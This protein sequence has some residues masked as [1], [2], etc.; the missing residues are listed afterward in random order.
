MRAKLATLSL[1][2]QTVIAFGGEVE[3][4]GKANAAIATVAPV[5]I[6]LLLLLQ[7]FK[8]FRRVGLVLLTIPFA[9]AGI[10]PGLISATLLTLLVLPAICTVLLAPKPATA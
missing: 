1:P 5:G 9:L 10:F 7:Q 3:E 8:S 4:S 6:I 2:A